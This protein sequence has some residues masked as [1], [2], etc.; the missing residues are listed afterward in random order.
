MLSVDAPR[1]L[2]VTKILGNQI[3]EFHPF[4]EIIG[5]FLGIDKQ[6]ADIGMIAGSLHYLVAKVPQGRTF[7]SLLFPA[8]VG[9]VKVGKLLS[10]LFLQSDVIFP[11]LIVSIF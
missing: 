3:G 4:V 5:L 6:F 7:F 2:F 9:I 8:N 10:F 1:P 11:L